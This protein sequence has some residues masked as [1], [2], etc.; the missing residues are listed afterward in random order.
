MHKQLAQNARLTTKISLN[1]R[2]RSVATATVTA[3]SIH[4]GLNFNTN[5]KLSPDRLNRACH[6][7][8]WDPWRKR[9]LR[10]RCISWTVAYLE[11]PEITNKIS[12]TITLETCQMLFSWCRKYQVTV[13]SHSVLFEC[14]ASL[15]RHV[16]RRKY[17]VW[18]AQFNELWFNDLQHTEHV[19][20]N[21][22]KPNIVYSTGNTV[23]REPTCLRFIPLQRQARSGRLLY[24]TSSS[25]IYIWTT[26]LKS[27]SERGKPIIYLNRVTPTRILIRPSSEAARRSFQLGR[28][29]KCGIVM[30]SNMVWNVV[31]RSSG[32]FRQ[33]EQ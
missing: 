9:I 14:K 16:V 21:T 19:Q 7:R 3:C 28:F 12:L 18:Y 27:S 26:H 29:S 13:T 4:F 24:N 30:T 5:P 8:V 22:W 15:E 33:S 2:A 17:T 6:R 1:L 11:T 25:I 10:N 23:E 32:D 20:W 31:T